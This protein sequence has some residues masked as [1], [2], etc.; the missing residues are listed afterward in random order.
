MISQST[1]RITKINY[2]LIMG[3]KLATYIIKPSANLSRHFSSRN[4]TLNVF[5]YPHGLH[6]GEDNKRK[7]YAQKSIY[8]SKIHNLMGISQKKTHETSH[9]GNSYSTYI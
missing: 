8:K 6:S 3:N 5:F 1:D 9:F 4:I 7:K 2:M